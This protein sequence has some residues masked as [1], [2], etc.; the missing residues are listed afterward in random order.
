MKPHDAQ[1]PQAPAPET[2]SP[3]AP[4]RPSAWTVTIKSRVRAGSVQRGHA[5]GHYR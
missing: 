5:Y 1:A 2:A 3:E 4:K